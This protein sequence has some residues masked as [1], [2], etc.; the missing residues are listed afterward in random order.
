MTKYL[1][2]FR[3]GAMDFR[4]EEE[5]AEVA[6]AASE[7]TRE[8]MEAGVWVFGGGLKGEQEDASVVGMD[9]VVTDGALPRE[10]GAHRR[11]HRRRHRHRRKVI[12][13]F[14]CLPR[15]ARRG[16]PRRRAFLAR[17]GIDTLVHLENGRLC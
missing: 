3:E 11:L 9:G 8:A 14:A 2:S 13:A 4:D 5:L 12:T 15:R 17:L 7:M 10:Q 1:I 6:E 16:Q